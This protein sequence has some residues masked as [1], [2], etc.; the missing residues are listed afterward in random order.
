MTDS[1]TD[2]LHRVSSHEKTIEDYFSGNVSFSKAMPIFDDTLV[3]MA[4]TNRC[5]SN[6]LGQYLI[7]TNRF[8]GFQEILNSDFVVEVSAKRGLPSFPEYF[9]KIYTHNESEGVLFGVKA[10]YGQILMLHRWRI[11]EMFKSVKIIHIER[12][13]LLAQAVSFAIAKKTKQWTSEMEKVS[14]PI[15][16][17][18]EVERL[19]EEIT[20]DNVGISIIASILEIEKF[21]VIYE[22][23]VGNPSDT[24]KGIFSFLDLECEPIRIISPAIK[25]QRNET[26]SNFLTKF[27]AEFKKRFIP[28]DR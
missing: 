28:E 7:G 11:L 17:Y 24:L 1:V 27:R 22:N 2:R 16:E 3:L 12:M 18:S 26:N 13:D 19:L 14:E 6:L 21:D 25:M 8:T 15:F 5:G 23:L 9:S 4:F 10:S 20:L